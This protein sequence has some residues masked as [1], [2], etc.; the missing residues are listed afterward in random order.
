MS[1]KLYYSVKLTK[2]TEWLNVHDRKY[3]KGIIP[4]I[5]ECS[6]GCGLQ[7]V[8]GTRITLI[9]YEKMKQKHLNFSGEPEVRLD[10]VSEIKARIQNGTYELDT[11]KM[12]S[13]MLLESLDM[14][15]RK[16]KQWWKRFF[17][18]GY[19]F[20]RIWNTR[21]PAGL[22]PSPVWNLNLFE[23]V[24]AVPLMK[25]LIWSS[26]CVE[27]YR[28]ESDCGNAESWRMMQFDCLINISL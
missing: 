24:D 22:N 23:E 9:T 1:W 14:I 20:N 17:H 19:K 8:A 13:R 18:P 6:L 26:P 4:G 12:A 7:V 5:S 28:T 3:S 27:R 11:H 21:R 25:G 2:K 15:P 16:S 10:R